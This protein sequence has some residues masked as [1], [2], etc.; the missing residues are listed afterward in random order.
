VSPLIRV[1]TPLLEAPVADRPNW[2]IPRLIE[3]IKR[4]ER[5]TVSR[6]TLS[7]ALRKKSSGS[8][9]RGTR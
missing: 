9:G 3:E 5:V 2:T 8:G 4:K 1:V 7:K 6:S